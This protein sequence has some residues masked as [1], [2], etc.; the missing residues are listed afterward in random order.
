MRAAILGND[1][2]STEP[3]Y[4]ERIPAWLKASYK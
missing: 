2:R 3:P 1:G 4:S